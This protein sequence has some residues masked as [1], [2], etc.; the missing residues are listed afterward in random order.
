MAEQEPHES[1][2]PDELETP[3]EDPPAEGLPDGKH[4]TLDDKG[5][6]CME[7]HYRNGL[8]DGEMRVFDDSGNVVGLF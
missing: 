6:P 1:P 7:S 5:N 8:L 4:V 3:E 2:N